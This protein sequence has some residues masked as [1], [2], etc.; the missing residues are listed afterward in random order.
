MLLEEFEDYLYELEKFTKAMQDYIKWGQV[1][2]FDIWMSEC[3]KKAEDEY[4]QKPFPIWEN[5]RD[6]LIAVLKYQEN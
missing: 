5:R 6:D 2:G 4:K 1:K 3:T